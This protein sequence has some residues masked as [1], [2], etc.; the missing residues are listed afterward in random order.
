MPLTMA[1][2]VLV[3]QP[4]NMAIG[5]LAMFGFI[6]FGATLWSWCIRYERNCAKEVVREIADAFRALSDQKL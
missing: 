3:A 5:V 6:A 2:I 4:E 1:V